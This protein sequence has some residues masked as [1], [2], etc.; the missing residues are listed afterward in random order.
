MKVLYFLKCK[1]L[2]NPARTSILDK[3][4]VVQPNS[5]VQPSVYNTLPQ[6]VNSGFTSICPIRPHLTSYRV[7][8][9]MWG[10]YLSL[11]MCREVTCFENIAELWVTL[12]C[13]FSVLYYRVRITLCK[14]AAWLRNHRWN[15]VANNTMSFYGMR[16]FMYFITGQVCCIYIFM[17]N[18][19]YR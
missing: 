16:C 2:H 15:I 6:S 19:G 9:R 5:V 7:F 17:T 14:M 18:E 3:S 13:H 11:C 8:F 10:E 4:N 1:N 12:S